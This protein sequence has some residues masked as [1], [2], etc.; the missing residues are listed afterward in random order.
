MDFMKD[1]Q[2][3]I[4]KE[5]KPIKLPKIK[6]DKIYTTKMGDRTLTTAQK[7]KIKEGQGCRCTKCGKKF[8][9]W[10]LHVDHKK[11]IASYKNKLTGVDLPVYTFG[12]K[13]IPEYDRHKS[14]LDVLCIP[15]HNKKKQSRKNKPTWKRYG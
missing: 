1:I 12:K 9:K 11:P 4:A 3:S 5:Q 8:P 10:Q 13:Y 7:R 6:V 14:N 2:R 15:C